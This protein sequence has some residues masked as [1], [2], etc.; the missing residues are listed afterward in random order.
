MT[1]ICTK[2]RTGLMLRPGVCRF[3]GCSDFNPCPS[4]CGW[5]DGGQ[6]VCTECVPI[7]KAFGRL[8]SRGMSLDRMARAFARG[9]FVGADDERGIDAGRNPYATYKGKPGERG[10]VWN[11]G[12]AAGHKYRE[13]AA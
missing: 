4:G 1:R 12:V 10:R 3:C 7:A 13:A 11:L 2:P 8:S 5:S 6:M 9:F